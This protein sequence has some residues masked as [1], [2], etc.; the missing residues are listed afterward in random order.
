MYQSI[1]DILELYIFETVT[2][3]SYQELVCIMLSAIGCIFLV[4]LPF[5]IVW[6]IIKIWF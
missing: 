1:Y 2:V 4:A 3:G 6:R 5:L